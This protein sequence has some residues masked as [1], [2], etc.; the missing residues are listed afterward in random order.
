LARTYIL[1]KDFLEAENVL[2]K[3]I[4]IDQDNVAA[5]LLLGELSQNLGKQ[6]E[7]VSLYKQ[8]IEKNPAK[9]EPYLRL[10]AIY[11][12]Q[13]KYDAAIKMYEEVLKLDSKNIFA[14][15]NLAYIYLQNDQNLDRALDLAQNAM[16][17]ASENPMVMDT[18]GLVYYKKGLYPKAIRLFE[19]CIEKIKND[20]RLFYHLGL[21]YRENGQKE[22]AKEALNKAISFNSDFPEKDLTRKALNDIGSS[23]K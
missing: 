6:A 9:I 19:Q 2:N 10:S 13:K 12:E 11:E 17:F 14:S 16:E 3:A 20:P 21:A 1:K 15:N 8:A 7:A 23:A 22:K 4:K 18:L 5:I